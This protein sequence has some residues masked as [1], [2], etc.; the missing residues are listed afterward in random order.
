MFFEPIPKIDYK[1][2]NKVK[3]V[4]N[5]VYAVNPVDD[6]YN[7][8]FFDI[9]IIGDERP[10]ELSEKLYNDPSYYW[11]LLYVNRI[12][13]PY[14][15]W[16]KTTDMMEE[17]CR[18]KYGEDNIFKPHTFIDT[19]TGQV[20]VGVDFDRAVKTLE[21]TGETPMNLRMVNNY[22][23]EHNINDQKRKIRFVPVNKL[24]L[25]VDR[26]ESAMRVRV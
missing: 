18:S 10:E 23:Y 12:S 26:Y 21:D 4:T 14:M 25:F 1:F 9:M 17:Y 2:D 19:T 13:N 16:V 20:L 5:I 22:E 8:R 15:D 6:L 11:T 7:D 3:S 24:L